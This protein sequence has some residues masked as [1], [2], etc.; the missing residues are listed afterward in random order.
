MQYE[1]ALRS[2]M[3]NIDTIID[4][5]DSRLSTLQYE[6]ESDTKELE[7]EFETERLTKSNPSLKSI[8]I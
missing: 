8:L 5:Q 2:H 7:T 3:I 1:N 4:L 6:F